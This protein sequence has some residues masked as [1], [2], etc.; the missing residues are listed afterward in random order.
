MT[1][2]KNKTPLRFTILVRNNKT[3]KHKS[4]RFDEIKI[5]NENKLIQIS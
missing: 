1:F 4:I 5:K 2:P 3:K